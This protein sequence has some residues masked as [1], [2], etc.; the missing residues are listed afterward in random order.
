MERCGRWQMQD[1]REEKQR[2]CLEYFQKYPVFGKIFREFRKK[3]STLGHLG[4]RIRLDFLQDEERKILGGFLGKD[5]RKE[6]KEN[7]S[8]KEMEDALEHSRFAGISW[9]KVLE[10]YFQEPLLVKREEKRKRQQEKEN[11]F[12]TVFSQNRKMPGMCWLKQVWEERMEGVQI[13]EQQYRERPEEL[14][15][16]LKKTAEGISR[17]SG[18]E[19]GFT[20]LPV[21]AAETTG[22]PHFFDSGTPGEKLLLQYIRKTFRKEIKETAQEEKAAL[23]FQAG[24]LKDDLS[25]DVLVYGFHGK[26]KSGIFHAGMEGFLAEQEPL[27]LTLCTLEDLAEVLGQKPDTVWMVENPAVF[28]VLIRKYP[29]SCGICGNGQLRMAVL[30]FLDMV[31]KNSRVFYAG[32]YDPEGFLIAQRLKE[33][34]QDRMTLWCYQKKYYET[35]LSGEILSDSRLKKLE[36][37]SEPELL[38]ICSLMKEKKKAAYQEAMLGCYS[39]PF[40]Q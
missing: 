36:R 20:L 29:D 11:I 34:Y 26:K 33:R 37:I 12:E 3:Y 6:K 31:T 9:E 19:E 8:W 14:E 17:I 2:A 40:Q 38:P 21:F 23:L 27:R 32:D 5:C 10:A 30:I 7:L 35:Y 13:L 4:G 18:K 1:N 28:S 39:L 22:N 25:N 24:I 16:F 15:P